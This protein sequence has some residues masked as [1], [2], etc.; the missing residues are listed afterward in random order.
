MKKNIVFSWITTILLMIAMLPAFAQRPDGPP[1]GAPQGPPPSGQRPG[2][3]Y[4]SMVTSTTGVLVGSLV[5]ENAKPVPYAT[6]YIL[7]AKD[8]TTVAYGMTDEDGRFAISGIPFGH[9]ILKIDYMGYRTFYSQP[10]VLSMSNPVYKIQQLKLD[11]KATMLGTVEIK[12]EREM[13]Q[14][15]LDK[16]AI[17]PLTM[18]VASPLGLP[19]NASNWCYR[20]SA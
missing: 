15:N 6:L 20:Y 18:N 7:N 14:S 13:L 8:S 1:P 4:S 19:M 2:R 12:A 5:D 10:F 17:M 16:K 3:D 9:S 11:Q